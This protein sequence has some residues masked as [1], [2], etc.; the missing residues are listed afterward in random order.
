MNPRAYQIIGAYI[1]VA[2]LLLLGVLAIFIPNKLIGAKGTEEERRKKIRILKISG[3][4]IVLCSVGKLL[5]KL[6]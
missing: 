4:V 5:M 2:F 1:D 3:G 6:I